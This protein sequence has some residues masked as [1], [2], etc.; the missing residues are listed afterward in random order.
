MSISFSC[1]VLQNRVGDAL[2]VFRGIGGV[3]AAEEGLVYLY[4]DSVGVDEGAV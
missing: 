2:V 1:A 3:P 4:P